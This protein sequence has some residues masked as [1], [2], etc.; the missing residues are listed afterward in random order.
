MV[1]RLLSKSP[2]DRPAD[3]KDIVDCFKSNLNDVE[4]F[5]VEEIKR[6]CTEIGLLEDVREPVAVA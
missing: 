2:Q 6:A 4:E 3:I 5:K 1:M